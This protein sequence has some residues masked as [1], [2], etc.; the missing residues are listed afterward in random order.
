MEGSKILLIENY[1]N[2]QQMLDEVEYLQL[3]AGFFDGQTEIWSKLIYKVEL[4]QKES[5]KEEQELMDQFNEREIE[6]EQLISRLKALKDQVKVTN[7]DNFNNGNEVKSNERVFVKVDG[8]FN[9][10]ESPECHYKSKLKFH[11][12][13]HI[14]AIH[15]KVKNFKCPDCDRGWFYKF[16]LCMYS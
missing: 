1:L 15:L 11:L 12:M 6:K 3:K 7:D 8:F 14:N 10:P 16:I 4:S 9:C 13:D 5:L 2:L